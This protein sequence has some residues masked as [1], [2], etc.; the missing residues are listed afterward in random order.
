MSIAST[1]QLIQSYYDLFNHKDM[2]G[3][4]DLLAE[5]VVHEINQGRSE[6]GKTAFKAF[7]NHM[8]QCYDEQITDLVIMV[9]SSG[10][11]ASARFTVHGT[12]LQTDGNFPKAYGQSYTLPA[13]GYF[14]IDQNKITRVSTY[15]NV[16][17]WIKQV[18]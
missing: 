1:T 2:P 11:H 13:V 16:P 8:N 18:S 9:D 5:H 17:E 15:Y 3:F 6:Q 4:L 12:Y 10:K 7:L 14:E